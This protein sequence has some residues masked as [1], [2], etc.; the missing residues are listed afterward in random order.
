MGLW[1]KQERKENGKKKE[2]PDTGVGVRDYK[3]HAGMHTPGYRIGGTQLNAF[4]SPKQGA[5]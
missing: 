1:D 2:C 3:K 5:R 4:Q